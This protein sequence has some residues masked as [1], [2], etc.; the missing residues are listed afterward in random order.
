MILSCTEVGLLVADRSYQSRV[1]ALG[2]CPVTCSMGLHVTT[3]VVSDFRELLQAAKL[4]IEAGIAVSSILFA[5]TKD[6]VEHLTSED[7]LPEE[8]ERDRGEYEQP[9]PGIVVWDGTQVFVSTPS[10]W[11]LKRQEGRGT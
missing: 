4:L 6:A 8:L 1:S 9:T 11:E 2:F 3:F 5:A 7:V 10:G